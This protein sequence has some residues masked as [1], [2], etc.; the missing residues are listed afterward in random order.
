[1]LVSHLGEG[2]LPCQVCKFLCLPWCFRGKR[3]LS[4]ELFRNKKPWTD[5]FCICL[6]CLV[7]FDPNSRGCQGTSSW[8]G[9]S[10]FGYLLRL[11]HWAGR[12]SFS[13][14]GRGH[15]TNHHELRVRA[16]VGES[17]SRA[18]LLNRHKEREWSQR[19]HLSCGFFIL[20]C[21]TSST[22]LTPV[23]CLTNILPSSWIAAFLAPLPVGLVTTPSSHHSS[24][25]R[26]VL[27]QP[28]S[29][30]LF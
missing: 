21:L 12:V 14:P 8:G 23:P 20:M 22:P 5:P 6:W 4:T 16:F 19:S 1:M 11:E 7:S 18:T 28:A 24:V 30:P 26:P 17:R 3:H 27:S 2:S 13:S 15:D 25:S 9:H 29:T 10:S